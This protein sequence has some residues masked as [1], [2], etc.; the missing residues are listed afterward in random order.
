MVGLLLSNN[1]QGQTGKVII[2][3]FNNST[4]GCEF[5]AHFIEL[6]N[7]GPGVQNISCY[8][9]VTNKYTITIPNNSAAILNPGEIYVI[10]GATQLTKCGSNSAPP[11]A[12]NLNWNNNTSCPNCITPSAPALDAFFDVSNGSNSYPLAM[13]DENFNLID[14]VRDPGTNLITGTPRSN[15]IPTGSGCT[16]QNITLPPLTPTP[17]PYEEP[18]PN[19]AG[20]NSSYSRASDGSCSWVKAAGNV[21]P[22]Q[23]N[24]TTSTFSTVSASS[25]LTPLCNSSSSANMAITINASTVPYQYS[26]VYATDANFTQNVT[27]SLVT[28]SSSLSFTLSP[29]NPGYYSFLFSIPNTTCG[30]SRL[31]VTA[32]NPIVSLAT[33]PTPNCPTNSP[34][35][36]GTATITISNP[37]S[38]TPSSYYP[39]TYSVINTGNNQSYA[40]NPATPTSSS[41]ILV[42]SLPNANYS[43]TVTPNYGCQTTQNFSIVQSCSVPIKLINFS[44]SNTLLNNKFEITIDADAE[45]DQLILESSS[46]AKLF[47]KVANIPFENK[48]GNQKI[49]FDIPSS[50]DEFFRIVMIDIFG[51]R[52][53]SEVVKIKNKNQELDIKVFPNPFQEYIS[54]QHYSRIEE[55]LIV[56]LLSP[57]GSI[58]KEESFKLLPGLNNFKMSTAGISK[59]N[60]L[61]SLKKTSS[62]EIQFNSIIKQ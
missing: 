16:S 10:A 1:V 7:L 56:C 62:P 48:K 51:K 36:N 31:A 23:P 11:V 38:S 29:I 15:S 59:G 50:A 5:G 4:N 17:N 19:S 13:Y 41:P 25:S 44:G 21:T 45:L 8:K 18:D 57:N 22:G 30:E 12:V 32:N 28:Q 34:A 58:I 42:S 47:S 55:M 2:N 53:V 60:Y 33:A 24:S 35:P 3:E 49:T 39:L 46:D 9:I 40:G 6:L 27:T 20:G 52:L 14:A 37:S 54:L 43:V 61:L 26:Y